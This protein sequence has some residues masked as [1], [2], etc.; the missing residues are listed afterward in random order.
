MRRCYSGAMPKRQ[1]SLPDVWLVSDARNDAALEQV[2][3]RLPRGS[4]LIFRHYHLDEM[5]R[6]AQFQVLARTARRFGHCVVLSG[7]ARE[8]L[9]LG[10]DGAYGPADRLASG[11]AM[12]RLITGHSLREIGRTSRASALVLSP[13]FATASHPSGKVL[14]TARYRLLAAQAKEPVIAL[15]G[16]NAHRARALNARKW[17]A[18]DGLCK[19]TTLFPR[20]S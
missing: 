10:A 12:M 4:G 5:E 11:P 1:P 9:R 6:R 7:T 18:I 2:L 3:A 15:G 19:K 17:A 14:G 16:M 20:S 13:V 8:A